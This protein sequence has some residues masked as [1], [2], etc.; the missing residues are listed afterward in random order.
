MEQVIRKDDS[1]AWHFFN[2][3]L[4]QGVLRA[5]NYEELNEWEVKVSWEW[6]N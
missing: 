1:A 3:S 2:S 4:R 5:T 6:V